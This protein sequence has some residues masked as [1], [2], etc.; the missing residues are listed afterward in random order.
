MWRTQ[1]LLRKTQ[2][3]GCAAHGLRACV[4][5][6]LKFPLSANA[7]HLAC[8]SVHQATMAF[9]ATQ[10]QIAGARSSPSLT[11]S[12]LQRQPAP[13]AAVRTRTQK[14]VAAF[15]AGGVSD[16]QQTTQLIG[17]AITLGAIGLAAAFMPAQSQRVSTRGHHAI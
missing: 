17:E 6:A 2:S 10:Q 14:A 13:R 12:P 1:G 5:C 11:G 9:A 16:T 3:L 7:G 15:F 8:R 4:A